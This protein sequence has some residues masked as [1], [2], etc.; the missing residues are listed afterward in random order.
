MATEFTFLSSLSRTATATSPT[1][2]ADDHR[3]LWMCLDITVASTTPTLNVKLQ[4]FDAV[5]DSF[6]DIPGAAYAEQSATS[7]TGFTIYPGIAETGDVSVSDHVG[8]KVRAL[9]TLAGASVPTLTYSLAGR[10]LT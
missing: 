2:Q 4:R 3:G 9:A 1:L 7:T 8:D 5:S 6:I 10:W